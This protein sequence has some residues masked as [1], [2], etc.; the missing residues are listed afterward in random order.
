MREETRGKRQGATRMRHEAS[1][2][3]QEARGKRAIG[4]RQ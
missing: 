4:N 3:T 2:K 1:T